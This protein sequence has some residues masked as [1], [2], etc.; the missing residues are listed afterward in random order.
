MGSATEWI[1]VGLS[2]VQWVYVSIRPAY[3]SVVADWVVVLS[4]F[5]VVVVVVGVRLDIVWP[6]C[7]LVFGSNSHQQHTHTQS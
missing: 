4:V 7:L 1:L 5:E 3:A 6:V 2:L